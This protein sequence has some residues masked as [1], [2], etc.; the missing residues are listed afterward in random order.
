MQLTRAIIKAYALK[1]VST[2]ETEV[3]KACSIWIEEMEDIGINDE[4]AA[5]AYTEVNRSSKFLPTLSEVLDLVG[6]SK[7]TKAVNAWADVLKAVR[8]KSSAYRRVL[9]SDPQIHNTVE[10]MGGWKYLR[11]LISHHFYIHSDMGYLKHDFIKSYKTSPKRSEYGYLIANSSSFDK[12]PLLIGDSGL[13]AKFLEAA[14][15]DST[16]Q[17]GAIVKRIANK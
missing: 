1:S 14:K 3:K 11:D 8:S 12:E 6:G 9:F 15:I 16:N 13:C 2:T 5:A 7:D 4:I 17:A 10:T